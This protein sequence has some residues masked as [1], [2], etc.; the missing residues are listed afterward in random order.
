MKS[1]CNM[2]GKQAAELEPKPTS[3][4]P[5]H[6]KEVLQEESRGLWQGG[7]LGKLT[8]V[9]SLQRRSSTQAGRHAYLLRGRHFP[10]QFYCFGINSGAA[11]FTDRNRSIWIDVGSTA[12]SSACSAAPPAVSLSSYLKG[13]IRPENGQ[14]C[15]RLNWKARV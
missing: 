6:L 2:P 12:R 3:T 1:L 13:L 7:P 8:C 5:R 10:F 11:E 14:G 4:S 15:Y 9:P